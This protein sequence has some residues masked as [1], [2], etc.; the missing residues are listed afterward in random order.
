MGAWKHQ[1]RRQVHGDDGWTVVAGGRAD[2]GNEPDQLQS[3]RPVGTVAGLTEQKLL[4]EMDAMERKWKKTS[5]AKTLDR[6]LSLR[7]WKV[8]EAVCIGIGSFSKDWDHRY[9]SLWQLVLFRAVIELCMYG[10]LLM[11]GRL[12]CRQ[13]INMAHRS[14]Y[15]PKSLPSHR[16]IHLFSHILE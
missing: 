14:Y 2:K 7:E 5:C 9:R 6:M 13:Y 10:T 8:Q 1:K 15:T 12:T 3:T 4:Y 11:G 16:L